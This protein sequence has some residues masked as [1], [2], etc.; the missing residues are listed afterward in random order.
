MTSTFSPLELGK[1]AVNAHQQA[2]Q[3][4]GHNLSNANTEGYSRQRVEFVEFEPIYMP[5]LN[6]EETPGQIGQGVVVSRIERIRDQLL[7]Q[8]IVSHA[9]EEG[10]WNARDPYVRM[11][12]KMY[13]EVGNNSIRSKIDAFWDSWQ[14]LSAD[15]ADMAPRTAVVERGQ[16]LVDSI[17]NRFKQLKG[18]Q[19]MTN[20]DVHLSV[21]RINDYS[22]QI[23]ALNRDIQ[24]IQAMGDSP[25]DL[26]DR[27]DLFVDK[28][29]SIIPITIDRRDPDEFMIHTSGMILV[30]GGV[31]RQFEINSGVDTEGYGHISWTDTREIF[32]PN[33]KSGSLSALLELRDSTI[34]NEIQVLDNL[35][36]NFVDL[37][38]EAHRPGY[39]INGRTGIDFFTE[40]HYVTNV[41]GNYDRDGDGEYDSSYIF[42]INGTNQLDKR[43]QIGLEGNI[44][45]ST[46]DPTAPAD[47]QNATVQIPYYAEDTVEDLLIR[48][49]NSGADVTARLNRTGQLEL[50]G[51]ITNSRNDPDFVIRHVEDSGRFLQAYAGLLNASGAE[52][53][54]DWARPD[55]VNALAGGAFSTAPVA[56]PAGWLE[57]NPVLQRDV[58]SVASGYGENGR[59]SNPGNG[60]AAIAIAAIRN[61]NVMVGRLGTIDD[62]FADSVGRIAM[63]GEIS[64]KEME[65]HNQIMKDLL[66]TRQSKSGVNMDEEL[67][68]LIK[69]QHGYQAAA[70]FITTINSMLE[71][72]IQM[73]RA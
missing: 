51:T 66:D 33:E 43:A 11:M 5:G 63:L 1:R 8:Q 42:R 16:S 61:T 12:E 56:H 36:M 62:Y 29:S 2:L 60:E 47:A 7:D 22:R 70:R 57:V 21:D 72:L 68:N 9:G 19:D 4:T 52:G 6:R 30:Q 64:G 10:Y 73:G 69:Y 20:Q 25:N 27:R 14:E 31:G 34:E 18:L 49:N 58:S 28:L 46:Y 39:G 45:L 26:M 38:N 44:T 40:H 3:I 41:N 17:H 65:T 67:S 50:K 54:Y 13:L 48:V 55:A 32:S 71:T 35:S 15:P 23:A 59:A 53:A 24:R 37:V